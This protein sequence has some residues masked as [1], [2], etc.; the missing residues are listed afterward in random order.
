MWPGLDRDLFPAFLLS[1]TFSLSLSKFLICLSFLSVPI[2]LPLVSYFFFGFV[3]ILA[4]EVNS[5]S[6][7][8]VDWD[9]IMLS[10][11]AFLSH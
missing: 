11:G 10:V 5:R 8:R 6:L 1:Q 7:V 4:V 3:S 9:D 2:C